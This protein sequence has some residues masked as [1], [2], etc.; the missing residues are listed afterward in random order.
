MSY[1]LTVQYHFLDGGL[2]NEAGDWTG[3]WMRFLI[4]HRED[5]EAEA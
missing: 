3:G 4:M 1:Q 5:W 2:C